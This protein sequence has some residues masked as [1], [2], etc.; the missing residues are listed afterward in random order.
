MT[1]VYAAIIASVIGLSAVLSK[2]AP[3]L[4]LM[5][6]PDHR[7]QHATPTALVG[8]ISIFTVMLVFSIWVGSFGWIV[9]CGLALGLIGVVDDAIDLGVRLRLTAQVVVTL[10][11]IAGTGVIVDQLGQYGSVTLSLGFFGILF[12]VF[13]VVGVINA[14]N[15][16]DGLDGLASGHV[17]V[18]LISLFVASVSFS[19]PV[20]S[21]WLLG[22]I[23]AVFGFWLVNMRFTPAPKVFLGDAG[24]MFLGFVVAWLIIGYTQSPWNILHPVLALWCLTVPIFDTAAVVARR[25]KAGRSPFAPDRLHLHHVLVD[26]GVSSRVA[27]ITLLSVAAALNASGLAVYA[28]FGPTAALVMFSLC[29]VGFVYFVLHP[30]LERE[31]F[32]WLGIIPRF[33]R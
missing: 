30:R 29:F 22:F 6:I 10:L 11:A 33:D 5:D 2:S 15:M 8:G 16:L 20:Y 19:E 1:V 3:M 7:K 13:A 9:L 4:G 14:F 31:V 28:V 12:T 18:S 24:S 26:L 23:C 21:E 25:L 17:I 32:Q 27:V